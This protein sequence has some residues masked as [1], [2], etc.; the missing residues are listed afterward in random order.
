MRLYLARN[1]P[2]PYQIQAAIQAVHSCAAEPART[3]WRQ[4]LQ[5]DDHLMEFA[6]TPDA[7]LSLV[8]EV[9]LANYY[10][11]HAIGGD[12]LR[13]MDRRSET[14][15]AYREAL[16]RGG[17]SAERRCLEQRLGELAGL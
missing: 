13:R 15:A 5:L 11:F 1:Q 14:A 17:N 7:A 12:L 9:P 2:G 16:A 8:D 4:I 10:L 6:P 3:E